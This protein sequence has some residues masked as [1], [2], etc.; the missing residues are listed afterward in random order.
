MMVWCGCAAIKG[1][2]ESRYLHVF[3]IGEEKSFLPPAAVDYTITLERIEPH[4]SDGCGR[5]ECVDNYIEN[6]GELYLWKI[7]THVL[8][9]TDADGYP[10]SSSSSHIQNAAVGNLLSNRIHGRSAG[11]CCIFNNLEGREFTEL[12]KV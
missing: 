5:L 8:Y 3:E 11:K 2:Q 10:F 4:L 1:L 7:D 9:S 6:I 12:V